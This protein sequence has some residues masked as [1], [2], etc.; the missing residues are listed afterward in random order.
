MPLPDFTSATIFPPF[1]SLPLT[2]SSPSSSA[3]DD[4]DDYYLLGQIT[5]NMTLTKPTLILTDRSSTSFALVYDSRSA[6]EEGPETPFF[7]QL[8]FKKG[9]TLVIPNAKRT[10]PK[11]DSGG[12][13]GGGGG[14]GFVAV[15]REQ[16]ASVRVIPAGLDKVVRVGAW[17]RERE[18]RDNGE[19]EGGGGGGE[20]GCCENCRETPKRGGG[21][22]AGLM[23]RKCT[24]CGEVAYCSKDCQVKG[25]NEGGHKADCKIIKAIRAIWP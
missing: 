21:R 5:E 19:G 9:S 3:R 4:V 14:Q 1:P 25:W 20:G 2:T 6:A 8:G 7:A 10:P 12:G 22:E 16:E 24:G 13:G 11:E 18:K 23:M 17:L 15:Q